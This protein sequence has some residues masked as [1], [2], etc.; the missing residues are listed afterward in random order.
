M[1]RSCMKKILAL[2]FVLGMMQACIVTDDLD[3]KKD[4]DVAV[5]F[6][7][8][9]LSFN[10][11]NSIEIPMTQLVKLEEDGNLTVDEEGNYIFHKKSDGADSTII[12][13]GQGSL[14]DGT[15]DTFS[16]LLTEGRNVTLTPNKKFPAFGSARITAT[17]SPDFRP[18]KKKS[19]ISELIYVSTPMTVEVA[20]NFEN[21]NGIE[22]ID[23]L[24]YRVP[25]FYDV[26][27]ESELVERNVPTN[28]TH[29]HTIHLK[30]VNFKA[31]PLLDDEEISGGAGD[32]EIVIKG[33]VGIECNT[34]TMSIEDFRSSI[35]PTMHVRIMVGTMGTT[36][37]T[38]RFNKEEEVNISPITLDNL[39]KFL[40]N[41]EV[42][43]DVDNPLVRLTLYN[44]VPANI[45][46]NAE[47]KA[48]VGG[49]T[50]GM[51]NVG[52][53][54]G[55]KPICFDGA[56]S[57]SIWVSRKAL[58]EIPD[59]VKENIVIEGI[60][61]LIRRVPEKVDITA[62]AYTNDEETVELSLAHEY[63]V[64][65]SYELYAPVKMGPNMKI[66]YEKDAI[67]LSSSLKHVEADAITLST[68][69]RNNIPLNITLSVTAFDE[70]GNEL[71][72]ILYTMPEDVPPLGSKHAD[73]TI[74]NKQ[75]VQELKKIDSIRIKAVAE[76]TDEMVGSYLNVNQNLKLE[77]IKLTIKGY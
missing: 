53:A 56:G 9:G 8:A 40:S 25:T 48:S 65:P 5:H 54:Y 35:N 64:I 30:G 44:E 7:S 55:T 31:S 15:D 74:R 60:G 67:D 42:E 41:K 61:D 73:I 63:R 12:N 32:D 77:N 29:N 17:F 69:I 22:T 47:I 11:E 57:S 27:D 43:L 23:E 46:L 51:L 39:P 19:S 24:R 26:A 33:T 3:L 62:F 52:R 13:I 68:D 1:R 50:T 28:G 34:G 6:S 38:G 45:E 37:V 18:D 36:Q 59:T 14:C 20:I 16:E 76:M 21:V 75:G 70:K 4:I 10:G 66:V 71:K 2:T 58:A 49:E 72:S